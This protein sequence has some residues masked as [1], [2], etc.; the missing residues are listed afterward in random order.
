MTVCGV[1]DQGIHLGLDQYFGSLEGLLP[2]SDCRCASETA[3]RVFTGKRVLYGLL[4]VLDGDQP[5]QVVLFVHHQQLFHFVLVQN[6]LGFGKTGSNRNGDQVLLRHDVGDSKIHSSL[7][8]EVAVGEN[9]DQLSIHHDRDAGEPILSH[10]RLRFGDGPI[11][12]HGDGVDNHP[13]LRALYLVDLVRLSLRSHVA[14]D[15]AQSA[16]LRNSD[17]QA[18]LGHGIHSRA[19]DGNVELNAAAET[20]LGIDLGRQDVGLLGD[21]EDIFKGESDGK[22]VVVQG[23]L[24]RLKLP[25]TSAVPTKS[26][27]AL[28]GTSWNGTRRRSTF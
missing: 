9:T 28:A 15:D 16:E 4:N 23:S 24:S 21:Q 12:G 27:S 13:A 14:V 1:H 26:A 25:R 7:E 22:L 6:L 18:G 20:G 11:G 8:P 5:F 3:Q 17:G 10:D 19:H 2:H